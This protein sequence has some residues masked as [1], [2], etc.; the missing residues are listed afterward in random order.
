MAEVL[1]RSLTGLQ[2]QVIAPPHSYIADEP[3]TFDGEDLGP[4]PY[5]LLLAALGSCTNMTL[6]MYAR[7]KGWDLSGIE[8]TLS[9]DRVYGD[10]C[11]RCEES[12]EYLDRIERRITLS[13]DLTDEQV[14][15]LT[16]VAAKCPVH[17]TLTAGLVVEDEAKRA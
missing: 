11:R 17:K 16:R 8:T 14:H 12:D 1:V 9:N 5:E 6:L 7:H 15:I 2:Q 10:D 4:G 13:G 3:P